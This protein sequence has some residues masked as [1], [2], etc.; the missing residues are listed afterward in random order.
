MKDIRKDF[1]RTFVGMQRESVNFERLR[2]VQEQL[3][4]RL[5]E[6]MTEN[7]RQFLLSVKEGNPDWHALEIPHLQKLPALKWKLLNIRKMN[8]E[9]H[10]EAI[11]RLRNVLEV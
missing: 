11:R 10:K 5:L 6:N 2:N 7:D 3:S 9:K 1:D 8:A 4:K